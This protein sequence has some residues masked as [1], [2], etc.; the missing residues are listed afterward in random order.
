MVTYFKFL[1]SNPEDCKVAAARS[2]SGVKPRSEL[3]A[4]GC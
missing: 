2:T 3:S 1:Y 4:L